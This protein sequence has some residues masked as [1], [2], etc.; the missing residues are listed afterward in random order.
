MLLLLISW[1]HFLASALMSIPFLGWHGSASP[2]NGRSIHIST[3]FESSLLFTLKKLKI[4]SLFRA[5]SFNASLVVHFAGAPSI[6]VSKFVR[7]FSRYFLSFSRKVGDGIRSWA[8]PKEC[9]TFFPKTTVSWLERN[10][11]YNHQCR[12]NFVIWESVTCML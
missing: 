4:E 10:V 12:N 7:F 9:G 8:L 11:C 5:R 1:L 3:S 2:T 6:F